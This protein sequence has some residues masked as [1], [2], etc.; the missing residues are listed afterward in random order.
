MTMMRILVL[1]V[2]IPFLEVTFG[3]NLI[4]QEFCQGGI[5]LLEEGGIAL[6]HSF[7]IE[8]IGSTPDI[9]EQFANHGHIGSTAIECGA[10]E[11]IGQLIF[12]LGRRR[13]RSHQVAILFDQPLHQ[14]A[15]RALHHRIG[16]SQELAVLGEHIVFPQ[17]GRNPG[18]TDGPAAP[19]RAFV[20]IAHRIGHAPDVAVVTNE[21]GRHTL[22]LGDSSAIVVLRGDGAALGQAPDPR[23]HGIVHLG[24]SSHLGGPIVLLD[25]DVDRIVAAPGRCHKFVPKTLQVGRHALG[26]ARRD[27]QIASVLEIKFLKIGV[28]IVR[29]VVEKQLLIGIERQD[30]IGRLS[31]VETYAAE[32][33][34]KVLEMSRLQG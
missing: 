1:P 8:D 22:L 9:G 12:I 27:E 7:T 26:T 32:E 11:A 6:G 18:A 33:T 5:H 25:I 29:V 14:E 16:L 19:H 23:Q 34:L 10:F 4:R 15:G 2:E 21:P 31:Q 20:A 13:R 17:V 30:G 24:Q 28:E 3:T